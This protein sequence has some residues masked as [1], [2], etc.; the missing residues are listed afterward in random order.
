MKQAYEEYYEPHIG[1]TLPAFREIEVL[2]KYKE[3]TELG[4]TMRY[5]LVQR[6]VFFGLINKTYWVNENNLKW[7]DAPTVVYYDD[8]ECEG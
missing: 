7:Y 3:V 8:Y 2:P 1:G 4:H 5:Q 6:K